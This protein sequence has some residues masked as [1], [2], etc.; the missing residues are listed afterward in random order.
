MNKLIKFIGTFG[1]DDNKVA[2]MA[3]FLAGFL[4]PLMA[5]F[6]IPSVD[7]VEIYAGLAFMVLWAAPKEFYLDIKYEGASYND[8]AVD[9]AFYGLGVALQIVFLLAHQASHILYCL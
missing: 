4:V 1:S 5:F 6:Y 8:S 7:R 9:F 2:Q 3:H